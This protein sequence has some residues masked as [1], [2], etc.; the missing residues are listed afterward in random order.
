MK[1]ANVNWTKPLEDP[2]AYASSWDWTVAHSDYHF[3][4]KIQDK[5]G[6]WFD[7]IGSFEGDWQEERDRLVNS[8][9]PVNWATRK[10]FAQKKK[11][12]EMLTQEEY[13]IQQAGG[14]PKGLMLTNKN[15]FADWEKE[16]PTLY[17]MMDYFKLTS[18]GIS[19]VKWQAHVQMTGQMFNMHIDKLWDRCPE[20]P[21]R[22][23]RITIMLDDWQ[24]GHFYMYGN[25]MYDKW[26]AGDVH[27]FDWKNVPHCT[28][29]A[30]SH[31][32]A[33]LQMTGLK[34][35]RT[36]EILANANK[37]NIFTI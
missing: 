17:K 27:I 6:D 9:H 23:V 34:T 16:Y 24:P 25:C 29:N 33:V 32:R 2:D 13:D 35:E 8:C 14:D 11:D 3:N 30:S 28:A 15:S 26:R 7:V 5:P 18:D 37:D 12:P 20:D 4:D 36:R 10:H 21:E 31:P 22:V 19:L 1:F